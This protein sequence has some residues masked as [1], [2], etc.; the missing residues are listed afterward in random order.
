MKGHAWP[1]AAGLVSALRSRL[2]VSVL[3]ILFL[4]TDIT[5]LRFHCRT[6]LL[7]RQRLVRERQERAKV[8]AIGAQSQLPVNNL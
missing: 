6:L 8:L 3:C 1:G 2:Q 5:K 7:I 4:Q